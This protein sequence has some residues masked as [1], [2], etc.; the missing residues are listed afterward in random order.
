MRVKTISVTYERKFNLGDYNSASIGASAWADLDDRDD[1]LDSWLQLFE[2][3][4]GVVKEQS[5][6]LVK[7]NKAEVKEFFVG[8][9]VVGGNNKVEGGK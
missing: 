6:P 2:E 8:L 9:P 4:K 3:V 5:L 1:E 7:K